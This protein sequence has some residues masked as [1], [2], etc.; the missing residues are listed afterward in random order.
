LLE[1]PRGYEVDSVR[2]S[3]SLGFFEPQVGT[4]SSLVHESPKVALKPEDLPAMPL[5]AGTAIEQLS[6]GG[7]NRF[8]IAKHAGIES[9]SASAFSV[10]SHQPRNAGRPLEVDQQREEA[11]R[12]ST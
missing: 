11:L 9:R 6:L 3:G 5:K 8:G 1:R 12:P 10:L 7:G 2:E 4:P